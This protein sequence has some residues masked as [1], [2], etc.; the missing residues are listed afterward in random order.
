MNRVQQT[1]QKEYFSKRV[2]VSKE[3]ERGQCSH[4]K[5]KK[6]QKRMRNS[7]PLSYAILRSPQKRVTLSEIYSSIQNN[8]PSFTQNRVRWKNTFR[9]NLS[10]HECF[11]R[12]EIAMDKAGCYWHIH[13][14]FLE[15]FS[16]GD[17]SRHKSMPKNPN[18]GLEGWN[19]LD[20]NH[21]AIQ[22][23]CLPCCIHKI[24]SPFSVAAPVEPLQYH[25]GGFTVSTLPCTPQIAYLPWRHWML[26][27]ISQC[28][29]YQS[30]LAR[31]RP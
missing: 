9:H 6:K 27:W 23:P 4:Q 10:L 25:Y 2:F 18:L 30:H 15:A 14:S 12:G 17:F 31:R 26:N 20:E 5:Q 3:E 13:P 29:A 19:S 16:R 28:W 24:N 21:I 1:R 11:Q 7:S 22:R 8:H